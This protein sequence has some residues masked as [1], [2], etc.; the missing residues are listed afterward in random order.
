MK[1]KIYFLKLFKSHNIIFKFI[2]QNET[3]KL[4]HI[5]KV[6]GGGA[7]LRTVWIRI[8]GIPYWH[9]ESSS[10]LI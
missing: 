10:S 8:F 9:L 7:R 5:I 6:V 2:I 4:L 3:K 1:M